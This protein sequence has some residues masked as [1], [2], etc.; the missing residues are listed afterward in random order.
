[1]RKV[2]VGASD[3]EIDGERGDSI[4]IPGGTKGVASVEFDGLAAVLEGGRSDLTGA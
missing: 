1:M 4:V 2:M 3:A